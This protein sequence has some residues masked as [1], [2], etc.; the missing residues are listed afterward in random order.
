MKRGFFL[1][2]LAHG[3]LVFFLFANGIFFMPERQYEN[4]EKLDI[5]I[6]SEAEFDAMTSLPPA[7]EK[8]INIDPEKPQNLSQDLELKK[9]IAEI[10]ND[11]SKH[12]IDRLDTLTTQKEI[13]EPLEPLKG[14]MVDANNNSDIKPTDKAKLDL[15]IKKSG[16]EFNSLDK[17][18]LDNPKPREAERIDRIASDNKNTDN[19]SDD[20]TPLI[21]DNSDK[22]ELEK[23]ENPK[24]ANKEATTK[25]T[26]N[27]QKDIE[28]SSGVVEKSSIPLDRS[29]SEKENSDIVKL[30]DNVIGDL[31]NNIDAILKSPELVES[32]NQID[33]I[34]NEKIENNSNSIS[35]LEKLKLQKSISQLIGRQWNK[36][37]LLGNA[38]RE[39]YVVKVEIELDNQGN[40]GSIRPV[41]P[42]NLVGHYVVAFREASNAIKAVGRIPISSEKYNKGLI[43]KLTFDPKNGIGF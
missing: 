23:K 22:F 32:V 13:I 26:P 18:T 27:S 31:Q 10:S 24:D 2:G 33:N 4:L 42:S 40:I 39:N 17:P 41:S 1:S 7:I 12:S 9:S 3:L 30:D 29:F 28:I 38:N 15:K 43:L 20:L 34:K 35:T 19:I 6:L 8:I 21:N 16:N 25:I 14:Y 37:I 11:V 5:M 36:G